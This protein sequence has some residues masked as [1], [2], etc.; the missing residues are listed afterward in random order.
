MF[1]PAL[2][3]AAAAA[4]VVWGFI[5]A[6]LHRVRR[7]YVPVLPP[8]SRPLRILQVSDLHLRSSTHRL[9]EFLEGLSSEEYDIVLAT[10]DLL[11][12]PGIVDRCAELLNGLRARH[13]RYFVFGSSDYFQPLTKG[14]L[15]YF[16][17]R[18]RFGNKPMPTD[19]F[20][21]LLK[22]EG[23]QDLTNTNAKC[24]AGS[25]SIQLTGMDD[26]H[27][28]W[29]DRTVL[30]RDPKA[31]V[32]ICV[33]H[34]PAPYRDAAKAGYDLQVSGH[35]HG[36]QV[37]FPFVGALVTNST[38]PTSLA[39]GL[40]KVDGMHLLVSPGLG[41]GKLAPF[42]FLCRPEASLIHLVPVEDH[43]AKRLLRAVG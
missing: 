25:L 22:A 35:T 9:I 17:K 29:E 31:D 3:A 40:A 2:A 16:L 15:D 26:P 14:Y 12:Q 32:A 1:V 18:K 37:R 20:K 10:G 27:L 39:R 33:V 4:G 43:P 5:E 13:G 34:D 24:A 21:E 6:R 36:G 7:Y 23:W 30:K 8:K 42:R 11:S 28:E 38:I 41:T 19:R